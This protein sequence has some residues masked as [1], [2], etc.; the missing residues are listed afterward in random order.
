MRKKILNFLKIIFKL[1]LGFLKPCALV[2]DQA[3]AS[4]VNVDGGNETFPSTFL[5]TVLKNSK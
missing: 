5:F 2:T 1:F 4:E 3:E